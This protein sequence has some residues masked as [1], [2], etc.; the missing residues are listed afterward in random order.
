MWKFFGSVYRGK[1]RWNDNFK[2]KEKSD[3]EE[4]LLCGEIVD[5]PCYEEQ[6]KNQEG[7]DGGDRVDQRPNQLR[8]GR[9]VSEMFVD[10]HNLVSK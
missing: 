10:F 4:N 1:Y 7:G 5:G 8:H 3:K 9:P 2:E 6:E